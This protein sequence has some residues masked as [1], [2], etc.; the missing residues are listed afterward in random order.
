MGKH[1]AIGLRIRGLRESRGLSQSDVASGSGLKKEYIS[2]IENQHII[3]TFN[4]LEALAKGM[5][6][7]VLDIVGFGGNNHSPR[8][9]DDERKWSKIY[10]QIQKRPAS[11]RRRIIR[12]VE[13]IISA[14]S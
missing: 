7:D 6:V 11:D 8:L 9:T 10:Q 12:N 5:K 2:R 3:P 4:T 13:K 14:R 1:L